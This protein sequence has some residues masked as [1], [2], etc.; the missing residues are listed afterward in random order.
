MSYGFYQPA[1]HHSRS[2]PTWGTFVRRVRARRT[3]IVQGHGYRT[4]WPSSTIRTS[5]SPTA[6]LSAVSVIRIAVLCASIGVAVCLVLIGVWKA[7]SAAHL[8]TISDAVTGLMPV[9]W[10]ASFGLMAIHA[11]STTSGVI[12]VY[13]I[14][15]LVNAVLYG[16]VGLVVAALIRLIIARG[17]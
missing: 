4:E 7:S 11:G 1:N 16:V 12:F 15:I 2:L 6:S 17:T 14:L 3:P 13:M 8:W 10:P 9:L 5:G